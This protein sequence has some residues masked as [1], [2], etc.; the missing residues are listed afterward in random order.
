MNEYRF[1]QTQSIITRTYL[2][3]KTNAHPEMSFSGFALSAFREP[4]GPE[5]SRRAISGQ[6]DNKTPLVK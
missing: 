6:L 2:Q 3:D 1:Q 5:Q 4:Q